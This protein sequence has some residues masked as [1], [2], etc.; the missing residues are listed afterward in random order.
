[1]EKTGRRLSLTNKRIVS[2][3]NPDNISR[4]AATTTATRSQ[5]PTQ[6]K[7]KRRSSNTT[8]NAGPHVSTKS[9]TAQS[10]G[11]QTVS[12]ETKKGVLDK[13][14]EA[15]LWRLKSAIYGASA[16]NWKHSLNHKESPDDISYYYLKVS[17]DKDMKGLKEL[18]K[19]NIL[20]AFNQYIESVPAVPCRF[21]HNTFGNKKKRNT[22]EGRRMYDFDQGWIPQNV[23]LLHHIQ[24]ALSDCFQRRNDHIT[25]S[26][27]IHSE[28]DCGLQTFHCDYK[29][30]NLSKA[31]GMFSS[32]GMAYS[33]IWAL[34]DNTKL[35]FCGDEDSDKFTTVELQSG[36]IIIF[37]ANLLH[38]GCD[39]DSDNYRVFFCSTV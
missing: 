32:P 11:K 26:C 16:D 8:S 33:V 4:G 24:K 1:M 31:S 2:T 3:S 6:S 19:N 14:I 17:M 36:D 10:N 20:G 25:G 18:I 30:K 29:H 34:Q 38:R 9:V 23:P 37:C 5:T 27:L 28:K 39:Y 7:K 22:K 13:E 21:I 35:D 12:T 15:F